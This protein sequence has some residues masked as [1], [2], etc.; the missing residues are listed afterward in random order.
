MNIQPD[1]ERYE[2]LKADRKRFPVYGEKSFPSLDPALLYQH[3]YAEVD[4][5]FI[6][7]SGKGPADTARFS[8]MG[9]S[10]SVSLRMQNG[11][12][13]YTG[14]GESEIALASPS[15]GFARLEFEQVSP[16]GFPH[17]WGGW[18][19]YMGYEMAEFF[20]HLPPRKPEGL[21][22]PDLYF[23]Q[24]DRVWVYDHLQETL[25]YVIAVD[26]DTGDYEDCFE[27]IHAVWKCI[28][29]ISI[30]RTQ[31]NPASRNDEKLKHP[32]N[33]QSNFT[34]CDY[35]HAVDRAKKYISDGDI[36]QANLS[37]RFQTGFTGNPFNLY[38]RL[39]EVNPSPFA[40]FLRFKNFCMVSSSP[41]RLIRVE[42]DTLETRPI[43]GTR[44]RGKTMDED[45]CLS[46]ELLLNEKEKAEHLMLVD[47]ERNDMGRICTLGSVRV[48]DL[49]FLEQ[50][51]HVIHIVSNI[52]G[53]LRPGVSV[54]EII[55]AVFP[56]GTITGCPKIRC[57]EIINE[58]ESTPR[59]P[60]TGS[61]GYIGF[62]RRMDLNIII[63]TILVKDGQACFHVGAGIVADS[64][65]GREYQETLDKAAAMMKALS[66]VIGTH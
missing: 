60:Y 46:A 42:N 34:R 8:I 57:M 32:A 29:Q 33:L 49:M 22:F 6:L 1:K 26:P 31:K 12:A 24:A 39:R 55:K 54:E 10:N 16:D 27:E 35:M 21:D 19:G 36:Y 50:Y 25:K 66:P 59:G 30:G 17:F 3:L 7:E 38:K 13:F 40:G 53:K 52:V 2:A 5:S 63:R 64:D 28:E 45:R 56:G 15:D 20:E 41:E 4:D 51:S 37:Q 58:L 9:K 65:P 62:S 48:T 11:R 44:P 18:V 43:A 61:F 14:K 23:M 47:L